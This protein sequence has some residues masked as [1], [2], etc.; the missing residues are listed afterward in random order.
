MFDLDFVT[1]G[2]G[3]RRYQDAARRLGREAEESG[4]FAE[5]SVLTSRLLSHE[6]RRQHRPI[7][8]TSIPGYGYWVWKPHVIGE[9]LAAR[10][11]EFVLYADA[12]CTLNLRSSA[13]RQRLGVYLDFASVHSVCSFS[14]PHL[15]ENAWTKRD[16]RRHLGLDEKQQTSGQRV[17]GVILFKRDQRS[18]EIVETWN[19]LSTVD[20]YRLLD[21]SPS[22]CGEDE[23]FRRHRHDQSILSCILK[24]MDIPA[25]DDETYF[26]ADWHDSG[27]AY[28]IWATRHCRPWSFGTEPSIAQRTLFHGIDAVDR[29]ARR[30]IRQ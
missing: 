5:V 19:N 8:R 7:L 6:F 25:L 27:S 4:V 9:V 22:R 15:P 21:D 24:S 17:G 2:G 23:G 12:G 26:G 10:R 29:S 3:L 20:S 28:P 11:T 13:A 16:V 30:L 14:M 1:F 18:R